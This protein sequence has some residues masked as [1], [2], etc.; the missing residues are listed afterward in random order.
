MRKYPR[1]TGCLVHVYLQLSTYVRHIRFLL[2]ISLYIASSLYIYILHMCSHEL[3][4]ILKN[5]REHFIYTGFCP[6]TRARRVRKIIR[7][8]Y[9]RL[10]SLSSVFLRFMTRFSLHCKLG[11]FFSF[12]HPRSMHKKVHRVVR[13]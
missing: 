9:N 2:Y 10:D 13:Y 1:N 6:R 8:S 11:Y 5:Y 3:A 4:N 12:H 7:I